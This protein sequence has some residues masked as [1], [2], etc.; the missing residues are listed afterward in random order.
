MVTRV[1]SLSLD[2]GS[3]TLPLTVTTM[4]RLGSNTLSLDKDRHHSP[5]AGTRISPHSPKV[6]STPS[7]EFQ[8]TTGRGSQVVKVSDRGVI[9]SRVRAQCH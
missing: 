7:R 8:V 6:H 9:L 4:W 5:C 2:P 3:N 1:S